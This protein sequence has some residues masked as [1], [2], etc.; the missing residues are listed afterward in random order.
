MHPAFWS[1]IIVMSGELIEGCSFTA[2]VQKEFQFSKVSPPNK[3]AKAIGDIFPFAVDAYAEKS[4][5][6]PKLM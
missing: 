5:Y 6:L 3:I 1:V 2:K 4:V